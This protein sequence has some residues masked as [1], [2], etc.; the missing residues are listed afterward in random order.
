MY[1][2]LSLS[3]VLHD[4]IEI[5]NGESS[6]VKIV[7]K[8]L[9]F[10]HFDLIPVGILSYGRRRRPAGSRR[11]PVEGVKRDVRDSRVL[12]S[13]LSPPPPKS[14]NCCI[15]DRRRRGRENPL[16]DVVGSF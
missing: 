13:W 16:S 2:F 10:S 6:K 7:T 15:T 14:M 9:A 11:E 4:R 5:D 8:N 12:S 1:V 3:F